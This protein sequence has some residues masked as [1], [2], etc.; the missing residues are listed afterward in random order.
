MQTKNANEM[1]A[2]AS[3]SVVMEVAIKDIPFL[4]ETA[5]KDKNGADVYDVPAG[6]KVLTTTTDGNGTRWSDITTLTIEDGCTLRKVT[7]AGGKTVTVSSNE[8]VAV[9]DPLEGLKKVCPDDIKDRLVPTVLERPTGTEGS[10]KLGWLL[11]FWLSDGN[12]NDSQLIL[13][14]NDDSH[15]NMFLEIL[16]EITGQEDLVDMAYVYEEFHEA[17]SNCGI[18]GMSKK[19]H[20]NLA[21]VPAEL[22][23]MFRDCYPADLDWSKINASNRSCLH[24]KFPSCVR[25]WSKEA[26]I[27]LLSGLITGDGSVS[28]NRSKK[29]PQLLVMLNTSSVQLK[30]DIIWLGSCIGMQ[31]TASITKASANRVQTHDSYTIPVSTPV[32]KRYK[33]MLLVPSHYNEALALLDDVADNTKDIVPISYNVLACLL[34][35]TNEQHKELGFSK[36][37]LETLKSKANKS[38]GCYT[39]TIRSLAVRIVGALL[40]YVLPY[41]MNDKLRSELELFCTTACDYTTGW[42]K[43][44]EVVEAPTETVYDIAVPDTKVFSLGNGLVVFDTINVHVPSSDEAVKEAYEK[45]MPSKTPF[46]DRV[47]DKVVPLQKQEQILGLYT[48]ATAPVTKPVVFDTEEQAI[49]A[50]RRGEVPLSADVQI[51]SGVKMAS[52]D[53]NLSEVIPPAE[54]GPVR[55]PSTGKFMP[56]SRDN[57]VTETPAV[58]EETTKKGE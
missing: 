22:R 39:H 27:G 23:A 19:F 55:N 20:L 47:E 36:P 24:K 43:V 54:K 51:R 15:R 38:A 48:A 16:G 30:D 37:S 31:M 3:E 35:L 46:S 32:L 33:D 9:F 1:K 49:R 45:L 50:I 8:S 5:R 57:S 28:I 6:M 41:Q 40:K 12:I 34:K 52:A 53:K 10:F 4:A 2:Q 58:T 56:T 11:G 44:K 29:K 25:N 18:G 14:K 26:L 13:A 42:E 17:A 7:T 21:F